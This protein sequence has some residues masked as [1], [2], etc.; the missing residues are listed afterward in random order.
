MNEIRFRG[1]DFFFI[2]KKRNSK[3]N[4]GKER[5]KK[6]YKEKIIF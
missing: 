2:Q 3:Q 6:K 4:I 1:H 5:K